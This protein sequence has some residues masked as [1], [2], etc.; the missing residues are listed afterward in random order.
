MQIKTTE[1]I[2]NEYSNYGRLDKGKEWVAIDDD[3]KEALALYYHL[4]KHTEVQEA[5][6]YKG[7]PI[8][9]ICNKSAYQI[10]CEEFN[11]LISKEANKK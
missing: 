4:R 10:M 5:P 9:K 8:C 3:I 11:T 7:M 1:Q 6:E 2:G